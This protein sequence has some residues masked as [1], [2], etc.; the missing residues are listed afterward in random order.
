MHTHTQ[1][2]RIEYDPGSNPGQ[3]R[4]YRPNHVVKILRNTKR[5]CYIIYKLFIIDG[6]LSVDLL[7]SNERDTAHVKRLEHALTGARQLITSLRRQRRCLHQ[8][9]E[10]KENEWA[11]ALRCHR[12]EA[13]FLRRKVLTDLEERKH[14][15]A[16][17]LIAFQLKGVVGEVKV[18]D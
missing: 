18:C 8:Y 13:A 6:A 17:M 2:L 1:T 10:R 15:L 14:I 11:E 16:G 7:A 4:L 9:L 12:S 3:V 5:L